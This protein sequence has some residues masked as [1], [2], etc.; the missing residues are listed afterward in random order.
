MFTDI[1]RYGEAPDSS[2]RT[3]YLPE[4]AIQGKGKT[5]LTY[6]FLLKSKR[7]L[8]IKNNEFLRFKALRLRLHRSA[9]F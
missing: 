8:M 1:N 3:I 4:S 6:S 5:V 9:A 2:L 7:Y